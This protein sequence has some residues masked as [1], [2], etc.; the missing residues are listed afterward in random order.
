VL[1]I[2]ADDFGWTDG[3]NLAVSRAHRAGLL[4]HASLL[5]NGGAFAGAVALAAELPTLGVGIHLTLSEGR[6]LLPPRRLPHLTR[7]DGSFHDRVLPLFL[8]WQAGRLHTEEA[9]AEWR[10]QIERALQAGVR[11]SHL[12]SHKHVHLLPPLLSAIIAL[13]REYRVPYVRLPLP[14]FSRAA[15]RRAPGFVVLRLL[16]ERGRR[17]LREAGVAF[18]DHFFGFAESGEMTPERLFRILSNLP[19][20]VVEIM[21]HPAVLTEQVQALRRRYA[22]ARRYRFETELAALCDPKVLALGRR[23]A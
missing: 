14:P 2:T 8:G 9:L 5:C 15:V 22:W 7:S 1:I 3:H 11:P 13:A 17:R 10:A 20:G 12:D 4:S 6:P 16:A 23:A 19:P 18:P 21:V